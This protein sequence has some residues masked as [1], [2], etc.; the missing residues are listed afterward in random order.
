C[1]E[2][3]RNRR[4][5]PATQ[6]CRQS[7]GIR[8][9]PKRP[10]QRHSTEKERQSKLRTTAS[11]KRERRILRL[12]RSSPPTTDCKHARKSALASQRQ[13]SSTEKTRQRTS[14]RYCRIRRR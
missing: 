1:S 5:N 14:Y 2:P 3:R 11:K 4:S 6:R 13:T 7:S 8:I 10:K 9:R 12:R